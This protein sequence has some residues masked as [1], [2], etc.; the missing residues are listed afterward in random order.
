MYHDF[1]SVAINLRL[2]RL[3]EFFIHR[4]Q[5]VSER[6]V[7]YIDR[8]TESARNSLSQVYF[9]HTHMAME[10]YEF[11]GLKSHS[12][13]APMKGKKFRMIDAEIL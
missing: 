6:I 4:S 13:G 10:G 9:G 11:A 1:Y 5:Q 8:H 2:H 3:P 7:Y 12:G